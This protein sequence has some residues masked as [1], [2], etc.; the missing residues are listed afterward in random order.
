MYYTS[1]KTEVYIPETKI[2]TVLNIRYK[3]IKSFYTVKSLIIKQYGLIN[4]DIF[5]IKFKDKR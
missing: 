3:K 4:I 2:E 1:R 5:H